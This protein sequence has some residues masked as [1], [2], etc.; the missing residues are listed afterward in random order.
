MTDLS[1]LM[2]R[3]KKKMEKVASES[4]LDLGTRIKEGTPK[5]TGRARQSWSDNGP[6]VV[7][8][9]YQYSSNLV[10]MRPLEYG[11][12]EENAPRG[13]VRIN[14]IKWPQIVDKYAKSI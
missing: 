13:M 8:K 11:H 3:Y 12:S 9:L 2:D 1:V 10:Y 14:T 5:D 7:G 4:V 6:L